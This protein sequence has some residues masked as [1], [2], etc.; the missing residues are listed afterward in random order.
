LTVVLAVVKGKSA[1]E[2]LHHFKERI[3][4]P[5]GP[6]SAVR[7][8]AEPA[9]C[10]E[11]VQNYFTERDI[12]HFPT[13]AG[14]PQGNGKVEHYI[15]KLKEQ[16]SMGYHQ[17]G[18]TSWAEL[19]EDA[20]ICHNRCPL[21]FTATKDHTYVPDE[22][23]FGSVTHDPW[24]PCVI[25][26]NRGNTPE[27]YAD[28]MLRSVRAARSHTVRRQL[29]GQ[30]RRNRSANRG[31][32]KKDF[33]IDSLTWTKFID[34]KSGRGLKLKYRGPHV[35]KAVNHNSA[36]IENCLTGERVKRHVRH[37]E[38]VKDIPLP[39]GSVDTVTRAADIIRHNRT[40]THR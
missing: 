4:S 35:I 32:V 26:P 23:M 17:N 21:M 27:Q 38:E 33:A 2:F 29:E 1:E 15:A 22:L 13:S 39:I 34:I 9:I 30:E 3:V 24:A 14:S 20:A 16:L 5:F 31:R 40:Q 11:L 19:A 6:P 37:L 12:E 36:I 7:S 28:Y 18:K 8:D 10:S 25:T